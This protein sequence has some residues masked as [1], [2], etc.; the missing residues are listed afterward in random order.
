MPHPW[1]L[2]QAGPV[3][4]FQAAQSRRWSFRPAQPGLILVDTHT[5]HPR[6]ISRSGI[7]MSKQGKSFGELR[8]VRLVISGTNRVAVGLTTS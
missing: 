4:S 6:I 8:M 3:G 5:P 7:N 1:T 2:V